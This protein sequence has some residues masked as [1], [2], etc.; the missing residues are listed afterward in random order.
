MEEGGDRTVRMQTI[1]LSVGGRSVRKNALGRPFMENDN[2]RTVVG[3]VDN[4]PEC[5]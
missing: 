1:V 3:G 2:E 4:A 5:M